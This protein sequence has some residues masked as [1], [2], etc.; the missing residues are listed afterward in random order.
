MNISV[1]LK[2]KHN[3]KGNPLSLEGISSNKQKEE[4]E[5]ESLLHFSFGVKPTEVIPRNVQLLNAGKNFDSL[6]DSH[7]IMIEQH[8]PATEVKNMKQN[9]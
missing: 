2:Y 6:N 1:P 7:S 8:S 5:V 4:I 3:H 9:K